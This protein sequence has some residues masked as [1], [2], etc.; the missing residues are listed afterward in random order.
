MSD[1]IYIGIDNGVSG[2]VG[3][4]NNHKAYFFKTPIKKEL[5]YTKTKQYINRIDTTKLKMLLSANIDVGDHFNV[6]VFLERPMVNPGRF[7]ATTS[8]L[9]S[10][11]A[12]LIVLEDLNLP[13][14][15]C[16]SK[17]WQRELLPSGIKGAELKTAS[18]DIGRRLFPYIESSHDD[19]D[20]LL[21]AE[22][23]RRKG[24]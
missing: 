11:E 5:N 3:I 10:L 15:Y 8:A 17:E 24:L 13:F 2:S 14:Q 18:N 19:Y 16:D 20:G 23:A 6:F 22:Y 1:K 21:I 12:T 9:R 7:K 4:I